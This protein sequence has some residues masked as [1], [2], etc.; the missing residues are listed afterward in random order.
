MQTRTSIFA[1]I[2][3]EGMLLPTD[4]LQRIAAGSSGL[5][6]LNPT[7][8]HLAEG[9]KLNEAISRSWNRLLGV[10]ETF[11]KSAEE[12]PPTDL[13]IGMTRSRWLLPLFQE[14]G[15]GTLQRSKVTVIEGKEYPISHLHDPAAIHLVGFGIDLDKRTAGAAGAARVSPHGLM[16]EFLNRSE[17]HLWGIVSNGYRLRIL[18]DNVSLTR[19]A[20]VEFDLKSMMD[21]EVY[22][23]FVLLWMLCHQSRLETEEG[24]TP[25]HCWLEKWSKAAQEQGTRALEDL[26]NGVENAIKALGS[27]FLACKP[28]TALID[29]LKS[30]DLNKQDYYRHLLRIVYRLIFLFTAEDRDLLLLPE[31]DEEAK[32]LYTRHY[33]T[34][35]LRRLAQKT[36]GTRHCDLYRSLCFVFGKLDHEGCKELGLPALGSFLWSKD[37]IGDLADCDLSNRS[38]LDCI[39]ALAFTVRNHS[40]IAVDYKNIGS[41]ELGSI[42]ESLL[43]LHPEISADAHFFELNTAGGHERKTTGSYYTPM[44]LIN[45]LLDSALEPVIKEA[46]AKPNPEKAV[47]DLKVCDPACGSGHFLVAAAH[48]IA[49]R[50]AAVRTGDEEPSPEALRTALRDVIGHCIYGVDINPMSVELCKISLWLEAIEPGKPLSFLDHHV[51]CG[52]SLLGTTPALMAKGIPDEAFH[53]IEGDVKAVCSEFKKQNREERKKGQRFLLFEDGKTFAWDRLGDLT[54]LAAYLDSLSDDDIDSLEKK[55]QIYE[56]LVSSAGYESGHLL[57]DLWCAAFVIKKDKDLDYAITETIFRDAEKN[58]HSVAD[59]LK[60]EVKRLAMAYQFFHWYLE[61]PSVFRVSAENE[62]PEQEHTGLC[63]GFDCVLGNPPWERIKLQE[64]EWFAERDADIANAPNAAARK[65]LIE[66]LE[67]ENPTLYWAFLTDSR[68]A[69]GESHLIRNG[70]TFPYCG[71]GDIN[72]YPVFAEL[73]R[74]LLKTSG[75]VGCIVPSGIA[76]DDTTKFFFQD[77]ITTATLVS[78][79]SFENEE[80]IFPDIHHAT[81]FCL[82][83]ISG[84]DRLSGATDFVFFARHTSHLKDDNRHFILS[85]D[86]IRLLNPNTMTC[87][88]FRSKCDAEISKYISRRIPVLVNDRDTDNGNPWQITFQRMFDMTNDSHLFCTKEDL[89]AQGLHIVGNTFVGQ[90]SSSFYVPLYEGKM[91]WHFDSRFGTF[92]GQTTAQA[93]QGKLPEL[94]DK[95]HGDPNKFPLPRYWVG[96]TH[97][98][99]VKHSHHHSTLLAFRDVTSSVVLRTSI[100]TLIPSVACGNNL[101]IM[102][103]EIAATSDLAHLASCCSSFVVDYIA[104]Q[105]LGGSHMNFFILKQLPVLSPAHLGVELL[106]DKGHTLANWLLPRELELNFTGFDMHDFALACDYHGKPFVWNEQRRLKIRA[107]IDAAF[108]HTYLGIESEWTDRSNKLLDYLPTPRHA[109]DYIMDTFPIVKRKDEQKYGSYRTKELILEIYDKMTEAI[110]TGQPYE[111]I[112][113]PPPGPPTDANGN[114]IP[115]AQWDSAN[116]PPHIHRPQHAVEPTPVLRDFGLE[117]AQQVDY[118]MAV[119]DVFALLHTWDKPVDRRVFEVGMLL[120]QRNGLRGRILKKQ[121]IAKPPQTEEL[122]RLINFDEFLGELAGTDSVVIQTRGDKQFVRLGPKAMDKDRIREDT[123]GQQALK[124]AQ[125]TATAVETLNATDHTLD[126]YCGIEDYGP[127]TFALS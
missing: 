10:W 40:L 67:T 92:D 121:V 49:K 99:D 105:C 47:L 86:D 100:F 32:S 96:T 24:K 27:G 34:Q 68:K 80:F 30:G 18:R 60:A 110:Q 70:G 71:R 41:E 84:N 19:Q 31:A 125:E 120:M 62:E 75:R 51:K 39:R 16:Q 42:Y 77:L 12:S 81:K 90:S 65:R 127:I 7:D 5:D 43:E 107:E 98:A 35:R 109:V 21:G 53:P 38:M 104:R 114:Y 56:Q 87:P 9:E 69:E 126:I 37:A 23:D 106:W 102:F 79:Y 22:S 11:S 15:Y 52:N 122:P 85:A 119:L 82:L 64:K 124:K 20:F 14:L 54:Q 28:N 58:P 4:L 6:G 76:T 66:R 95:D 46:L 123:R 89:E 78:L 93:N 13:G 108:F 117:P 17:P 63:G 45:C 101:P 88:I 1:T 29:K 103:A 57:A 44:S 36:S 118:A 8:Y 50:L 94:T 97:M 3:T 2:R 25:D 59:W 74:N 83:T 55:R 26:R 61:F 91:I 116:W 33:S 112:L 113:D 115:M 72:T 48:R 111:T 73:K